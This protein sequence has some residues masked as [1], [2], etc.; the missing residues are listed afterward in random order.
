MFEITDTSPGGNQIGTELANKMNEIQIGEGIPMITIKKVKNSV[1]EEKHQPSDIYS[2]QTKVHQK[3]EHNEMIMV[4]TF[5]HMLEFGDG[6]FKI[7]A[8]VKS[9]EEYQR[10][11]FGKIG[12]N[13]EGRRGNIEYFDV[14]FNEWVRCDDLEII[15]EIGR[16]RITFQQGWIYLWLFL[17]LWT[18]VGEKP[19][20][21]LR[22]ILVKLAD[23]ITDKNLASL[24]LLVSPPN[25]EKITSI[26]QLFEYMLQTGAISE[27]KGLFY[28][29]DLFVDIKRQDLAEICDNN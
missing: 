15:P 20:T 13:L 14:V 5:T 12:S 7:S 21:P 28:L 26:Q 1:E 16:I 3:I 19:P 23:H 9:L 29:R 24:K 25:P 2:L 4:K 18:D 10:I 6:K 27:R 11:V 8:S 22:R 17:I